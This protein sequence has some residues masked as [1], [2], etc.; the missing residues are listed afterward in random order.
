[1]EN[2]NFDLNQMVDWDSLYSK[3]G[4]KAPKSN[5]GTM[6]FFE[7]IKTVIQHPSDF[8]E[9]IKSEEGIGK[10][11]IYLAVLSLINL[12]TGIISLTF[13]V[14]YISQ[15][16]SLSNYLPSLG[17]F[18]SVVSLGIPI[19]IYILTVVGTFV[20]AGFIH[21]F[22]RLLGGKGSYSFTY[23]GIVYASTPSLLLG[24]IPYV[25]FI[26]GIYAF[27]LE[28]KGLSKLHQIG[29]GRVFVA[30]FVVPFLLI[31]LIALA[32]AGVAY[33]YIT[34]IFT[35]PLASSN[36][37][38]QTT[39]LVDL[40]SVGTFCNSTGIFVSLKNVGTQPFLLR[41][42]NVQLENNTPLTCSNS[43]E[44]LLPGGVSSF[45][46]N[47]LTGTAQGF[48]MVVISGT[49]SGPINTARVPIA[50]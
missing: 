31:F 46:D 11:F 18:S 23:K 12:A 30:I 36:F 17:K 37:T 15:L 6:S 26:P 7:K 47:P 49:E 35:G 4:G 24:W 16:S 33:I 10:T 21:L 38:A 42:V 27:Y 5:K 39:R 20:I 45:C 22:I 14:P 44:L 41:D 3:Y 25:G 50:C 28:L 13:N 19:G 9:R 32:L 34:S 40:D 48:N 43:A 1:V 8:F 2:N 29:M